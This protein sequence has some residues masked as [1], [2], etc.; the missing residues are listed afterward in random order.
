MVFFTISYLIIAKAGKM[1]TIQSVGVYCSSYEGLDEVYKNAAIELGQQLAEQ[2]ITM[3]YGGG[4]LGLMGD[5]SKTAMAHG[6]RVIGF[7]PR[8]LEAFEEPNWNIT[9]LHMV[10][11]MH[12]RKRMM[13]EH[14]EAFFI[15]PGGFGT[16][17]ETFE[18]ITWE[19]LKLHV[20]PIIFINI[21][22]YWAPLQELTS[23]IINQGFAL[24][25]H[26]NFFKFV[27][28]IPEAFRALHKVPESIMAESVVEWV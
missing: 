13:F 3:I 17:D 10:D 16:L 25:E 8:H 15:L 2:N 1:K 5:V 27:N 14:A 22:N 19:Q 12:T 18:I 9:E 7:M 28:S 4:A 26:K 24:S 21:N 23:N 6:G 20:K 11:T